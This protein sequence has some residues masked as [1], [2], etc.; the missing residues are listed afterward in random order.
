MA[1]IDTDNFCSISKFKWF[2]ELIIKSNGM[3]FDQVF[4]D[5]IRSIKRWIFFPHS[6]KWRSPFKLPLL[7]QLSIYII[8]NLHI[9]ATKTLHY[10][11]PKSKTLLIIVREPE[12]SITFLFLFF[13]ACQ[14]QKR[15]MSLKL[16]SPSTGMQICKIVIGQ[17]DVTILTVLHN[18]LSGLC[19]KPKE[20]RDQVI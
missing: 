4:V 3:Q 5:P 16:H 6:A 18:K 9:F 17:N 10:F 11:T 14:K 1:L 8:G 19:A 2:N 13:N 15:R 12:I 7:M 20:W